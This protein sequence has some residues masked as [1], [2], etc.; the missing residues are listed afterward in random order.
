MIVRRRVRRRSASSG[1]TERLRGPAAVA[2]V[3]DDAPGGFWAV[4]AIAATLVLIGVVVYLLAQ[5]H[6]PD[7]ISSL[8]G[9]V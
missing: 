1:P 5:T 9:H 6:M 2:A 3:G 4:L 8:P 7:L